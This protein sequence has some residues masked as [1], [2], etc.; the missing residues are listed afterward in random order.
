MSRISDFF[1]RIFGNRDTLKLNELAFSRPAV[2]LNYMQLAVA[3]AATIIGDT[4]SKCEVK[5]YNKD[6]EVEE[7]S[8]EHF[9]W[10][11]AP[12]VNQNSSE[13]I[14]NIVQNLVKYQECLVIE[15]KRE[16]FI[17]D[18]YSVIKDGT[19]PYTFTNVSINGVTLPR[20][21]K[22]KDVLFFRLSDT[23]ISAILNRVYASYGEIF[24]AAMNSYKAANSSKWKL[25]ISASARASKN[26]QETYNDLTQEK[27]KT[28]FENPNA[29]YPEF[30]GYELIEVS[31]GTASQGGGEISDLRKD[32]F[33]LVS[34]TYK[35]PLALMNGE[36]ITA[37]QFVNFLT[38]CVEPIAK[39]LSGE[40]TKAYFTYEEWASGCRAEFDTT[41]ISMSAIA[42]IAQACEKFIGSGVMNIDEVRDKLLGLSVLNTELSKKYFVTKNFADLENSTEGGENT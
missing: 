41:A 2:E 37:D 42:T 34:Q 26:F 20:E 5:F 32:I 39:M 24:S 22:R 10:N 40:V 18:S 7:K 25:K 30:E 11:V 23:D 12:N 8:L 35:L 17:A 28:F 38:L 19:R 1:G 31:K 33:A 36:T 3:I 27:L 16:L 29:V 14:N 6:N 4:L 15:Y 21:F 9:R 13:F